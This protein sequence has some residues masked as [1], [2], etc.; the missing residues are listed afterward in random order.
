[1][2][3]AKGGHMDIL[4]WGLEVTEFMDVA[5]NFHKEVLKFATFHGHLEILKFLQTKLNLETHMIN[6]LADAVEG[7]QRGT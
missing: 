5:S 1:L 2:G 3:A 6:F 4:T 7:N